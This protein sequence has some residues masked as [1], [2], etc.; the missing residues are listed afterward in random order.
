M[1]KPECRK[2][3][4]MKNTPVLI[5]WVTLL[6][7]TGYSS[8]AQ[9]DQNQL[10]STVSWLEKKINISYYNVQTQEWWSN[11]F[12]YSHEN[13][14]INF[15]STSSDGPSFLD[16]NNYYDRK[17][18]LSDLDASSIEVHDIK[19]DQGRIVYGQVVQVN[20]IGNQKVIQRTKN[21][22]PSFQEFFL[23]IPVPHSYDSLHIM[24]D[25]IKL[26]LAQAIELASKIKPTDSDKAN[27]Q[28][29]MNIF[30][31]S[32]K[33]EDSS[34]MRFTKISEGAYE[35]EH[36]SGE[37]YLREGLVGFDEVN[38]QFYFWTINR[39]QRERINLAVKSEDTLAI[40]TE[41]NSYKLELHGANH[42]SV[43]E[44]GVVMEYFRVRE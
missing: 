36:K 11:R 28:T 18:L 22:R 34:I 2:L 33:G 29:I 19:E 43:L 3:A 41:D 6:G 13:G 17:V 8:Q 42:F 15:K 5:L 37:A 39:G 24:A 26:K 7:L 1:G 38:N 10:S 4:T 21:G 12:F 23:Q 27:A 31:G 20:T 44:N 40:A 14:Q 25:S 32:F 35:I 30:H 9:D 16:R